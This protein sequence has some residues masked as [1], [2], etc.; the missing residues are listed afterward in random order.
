M[1]GPFVR[2]RHRRLVAGVCHALGERFDV[3]PWAIRG[4]FLFSM[5]LPGPQI[6]LYLVLWAL[7]PKEP[8]IPLA[9]HLRPAARRALPRRY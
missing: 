1:A 5:L 2:P 6:L 9:D 4:L 3:S 7:I 8:R